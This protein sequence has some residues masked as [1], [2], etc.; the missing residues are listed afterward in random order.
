M[1]KP[2]LG[3][4]ATILCS[5]AATFVL[6]TATINGPIGTAD[7][8]DTVDPHDVPAVTWHSE[9][10]VLQRLLDVHDQAIASGGMVLLAAPVPAAGVGI[11]RF[12]R[13]DVLEAIAE[14]GERGP[15]PREVR[16]ASNASVPAGAALPHRIMAFAQSDGSVLGL[17]AFDRTGSTVPV[18]L[19]ATTVDLS[20]AARELAETRY[21]PRPIDIC[22][23]KA[24]RGVPGR[25]ALDKLIAYV[26]LLGDHSEIQRE[27]NRVDREQTVTEASDR[28][29]AK[30]PVSGVWV[31]PSLSD[32]DRQLAS[33]VPADRLDLRPSIPVRILTDTES[34][35]DSGEWL[36]FFGA[37]SG[38]FLGAVTVAPVLEADGDPDGPLTWTASPEKVLFIT[39]PEMGEDVEIV[40]RRSGDRGM[41]CPMLPH[42]RAA[43]TVAFEDVAG[44][45]RAAVDVRKGV[46]VSW[47]D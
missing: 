42:E 3:S 8:D 41:E 44:R 10:D 30:D 9:E 37:E 25:T 4:A 36:V 23:P 28:A 38:D 29:W 31:Q 27:A 2:R 16:L 24:S 7:S 35:T 15:I 45:G 21:D 17:A 11:G 22:N 1:S 33:G 46:V 34:G 39:P 26:D 43:F 12:E 18:E 19:A 40:I 5:A 32:L 6:A 13:A 20:A 14:F 47:D